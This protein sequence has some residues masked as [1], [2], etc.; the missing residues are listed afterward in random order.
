MSVRHNFRLAHV[1]TKAHMLRNAAKAIEHRIK[2]TQSLCHYDHI[3][4]KPKLSDVLAVDVD[5]KPVPI[6]KLKNV[7]QR[8]GKQLRGDN[9]SLSH[10]SLQL[11]RKY[12]EITGPTYKYHH[13]AYTT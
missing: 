13:W 9:I 3:V 12:K 10:S 6:Q 2:V 8:S 5:A 11:D 4:G 1:H 7:H